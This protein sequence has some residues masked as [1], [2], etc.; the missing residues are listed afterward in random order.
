MIHFRNDITKD[1]AQWIIEF[2]VP[3]RGWR[4][5]RKTLGW[6]SEAHNKAFE[7]QVAVPGCSC[8]FKACHQVWYSR[9]DQYQQQIEDIAYPPVTEIK[10][11]MGRRGRKPNGPKGI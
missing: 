6:L 11:V 2:V 1:D 10:S 3:K 7:E 4:I 5:D 9:L 8:E